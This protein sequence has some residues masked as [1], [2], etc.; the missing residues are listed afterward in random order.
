MNENKEI[1][2]IERSDALADVKQAMQEYCKIQQLHN[3]YYPE[4]YE[5]PAL[6]VMRNMI[7]HS[8]GLVDANDNYAPYF[9]SLIDFIR[10]E[11]RRESKY[12]WIAYEVH[13]LINDLHARAESPI[14]TMFISAI[15]PSICA[16]NIKMEVQYTN[17]SPYR[18]DVAFPEYQ[19][20]VELDGHEFHSS[21]EAR[22]RD[23]ARDRDLTFRGW[24]VI[25]FTGSEIYHN[26]ENCAHEV[27]NI[28]DEIAYRKGMPRPDQTDILELDNASIAVN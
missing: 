4:R 23:A 7:D 11:L 18:L 15:V 26:A 2:H 21:K 25:R 3:E 6:F 19:V 14:E 28:L 1:I 16:F 17:E 8:T 9:K 27:M 5:H 12:S 22:Q 20:A 10:K 24:T 13:S